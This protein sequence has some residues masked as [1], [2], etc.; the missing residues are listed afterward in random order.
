MRRMAGNYDLSTGSLEMAARRAPPCEGGGVLWPGAGNGLHIINSSARR[1]TLATGERRNRTIASLQEVYA[2]AEDR[3][4][5]E[6]TL[7]LG[8]AGINSVAL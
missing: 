3:A 7:P 2:G 8:G 5:R 1:R 4:I 6:W